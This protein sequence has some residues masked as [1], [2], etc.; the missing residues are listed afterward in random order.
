MTRRH[1][2]ALLI[3]AI[4]FAAFA[5]SAA[6]A[7]AGFITVRGDF[8]YPP[9]E[10][11]D[12]GVPT[13]FNVDIMRAVARA[14]DLDVKIDLGPWNEVRQQLER[15]EIEAL[16]GMYYSEERDRLVDFSSPHIIVNHAIFVRRDAPI[17][18]LEDLR[19]KTVVVQ[20][21][22]IMHDFALDSL[23]GSTLFTAESQ[24]DA[25]KLVARGVHDAALLGKLQNLYLAKVN[26]LDDIM[27][28]GPPIEPRR[29]CIAVRE[30]NEALLAAVNEGLKLIQ[31]S[32]EYQKIH[33]RW[34]GV[35]EQRSFTRKLV[36]Y[37]LYA[38]VP[39]LLLLLAALAWMWSLS[40]AVRA[41]TRELHE[42]REHFKSVVEDSPLGM[43]VTARDGTVRLIN[44]EFTRM[45]GYTAQ[46]VP[47]LDAWWPRAYPDPAYRK[48]V[49][50]SWSA[51]TDPDRSASGGGAVPREWVVHTRDGAPRDIEF[52]TTR[53]GDDVLIILT[54]ITERKRTAE[55][56]VQSEKMLS[57]GG[58]AAGMAH[59]INNPLGGIL[60]GV[61][62]IQRRLSPDMQANRDAAQGLGGSMEFLQAY[63]RQRGIDAMLEGIRDSGQR[64][65]DIV[66]SMLRFSRKSESKFS[67]L[68][69]NE[70]VERAVTLAESDYDLKHSY[71]FR[72]IAII[73]DLEPN[74]PLVE[75]TET[76][77]VQVA[78]NLLRNAAQA[79]SRQPDRA[80]DASIRISTR[81]VGERVELAVADNGP[82]MDEA[83]RR[84][85]FE[86]FFTTKPPGVG[87]GLGLSVA[88]FIITRNHAGDIDV[89]SQPGQGATFTISLPIRH[90]RTATT[91]P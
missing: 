38:G 19:G 35:Y 36:R 83:V 76:E 72:K 17:H 43:A 77:I 80:G 34:F 28:V 13:G 2:L 41:R 20:R 16:T 11:L 56:L 71:D 53:I 37:A 65:A 57:V 45:L 62:N 21:G 29:Y 26:G 87:T 40:R 85:V 49:L 64:A 3:A 52:R 81:Q 15:G 25:L 48:K 73:R 84:R 67:P 61:Q 9:Y 39:V 88:Y 18:G 32:G 33:D 89:E 44:R 68:D 51:A 79:L 55:V 23:P 27:T 7:P 74:L 59:E 8:N 14:M 12:S 60:Q 78:F 54:D 47:T 63:L 58:L 66:K 22:D 31:L 69:L 1:P 24:E 10:F 70:L 82:G 30:G 5:P 42:S 50:A 86:P 46:D 4:L 90:G 91:A 75:C 6:P